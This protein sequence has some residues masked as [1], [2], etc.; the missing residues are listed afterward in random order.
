[1]SGNQYISFFFLRERER[2]IPGAYV[3]RC[4]RREGDESFGLLLGPRFILAQVLPL[5]PPSPF[6]RND[7]ERTWGRATI[8]DNPGE[9]AGRAAR[10]EASEENRYIGRR[11][12]YASDS[13]G[14]R[15]TP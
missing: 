1:M 14:F 5:P 6:V 7:R 11:Y 9:E 15:W 3:L 10:R 8:Q 4:F 2:D 13:G 12:D